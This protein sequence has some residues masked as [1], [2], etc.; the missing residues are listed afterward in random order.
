[1]FMEYNREDE[2]AAREEKGRGEERISLIRNLVNNAK[3]T[4]NE[5]MSMLGI[6]QNQWEKYAAMIQVVVKSC[7]I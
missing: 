7:R 3:V 6:P 4:V 1:M 2:L 5:A